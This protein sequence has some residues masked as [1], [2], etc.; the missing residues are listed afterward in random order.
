[1]SSKKAPIW[2]LFC[3]RLAQ[4]SLHFLKMYNPGEEKDNAQNAK[5]KKQ[6]RRN[7]DQEHFDLERLC[8]FEI[9]INQ[10][11]LIFKAKCTLSPDNVFFW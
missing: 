11:F 2:V 1:M 6:C 4:V 3:F 10:L 8:F 5:Y 9:V 7:Y